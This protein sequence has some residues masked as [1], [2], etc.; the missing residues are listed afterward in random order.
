MDSRGESKQKKDSYRKSGHEQSD[1]NKTEL[2]NGHCLYYYASATKTVAERMKEQGERYVD[3]ESVIKTPVKAQWVLKLGSTLFNII[4]ALLALLTRMAT[5]NDTIN[6]KTGKTNVVVRDPA[7][8]PT[9]KEFTEAF[10]VTQ[11]EE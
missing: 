7:N 8:L 11:K 6:L 5:V 1:T 4:G 3:D 9:A 10:K 2:G